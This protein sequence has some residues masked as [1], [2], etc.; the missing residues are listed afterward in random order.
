MLIGTQ[1]RPR[2]EAPRSYSRREDVLGLPGPRPP[3]DQGE[4]EAHPGGRGTG[5]RH[6]LSPGRSRRLLCRGPAA[7]RRDLRARV[8]KEKLGPPVTPPPSPPLEPQLPASRPR[9]EGA[10]DS[11]TAALLPLTTAAWTPPSRVRETRERSPAPPRTGFCS[12][13]AVTPV[14]RS[15]SPLAEPWTTFAA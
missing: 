13:H 6:H 4:L 10:P 8:R 11:K 1:R 12:A 15:T 2:P 5:G 3:R 9:P 7:G 14:L